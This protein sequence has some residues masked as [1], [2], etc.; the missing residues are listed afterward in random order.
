MIRDILKTLLSVTVVLLIALTATKPSLAQSRHCSLALVLAIDAS[1]SVDDEEYALQMKGLGYALLNQEVVEA[2]LSLGGMYI[3]AFEWNGQ[4][5]QKILFNWSHISQRSHIDA[6]VRKFA[7]HS[8]NT[9]RAPTAIGNALG[10]AKRL[11]DRAPPDCFRKVIDVSGDGEHNDGIKPKDVYNLYDFSQIMV[12]G[13]VIAG[14]PAKPKTPYKDTED[15]YRK[16]I[17]HGPGSFLVL[18]DGFD[19]FERAMKQKL[20]KEIVPGPVGLL[21]SDDLAGQTSHAIP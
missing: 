8:R 9:T 19:D 12:N 11:L 3:A 16:N 2:M 21:K 6:L 13:L 14:A 15:Y 18:A 5:N 7:F 20:L 10:F 17:L 4:S 1:S